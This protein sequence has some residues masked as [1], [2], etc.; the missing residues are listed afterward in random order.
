[1]FIAVVG[2]LINPVAPIKKVCD[3]LFDKMEI[4]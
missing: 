2:I 3:R 4:A 1:M